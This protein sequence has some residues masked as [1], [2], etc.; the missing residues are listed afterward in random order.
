MLELEHKTYRWI[1]IKEHKVKEY[2]DKHGLLTPYVYNYKCPLTGTNMVEYHVESCK[3]FQEIMNKTTKWGGLSFRMPVGT[4]PMVLLGHNKCIYKQ[5]QFTGKSWVADNG[6]CPI[7]PK[8]KGAGLM[9]SNFQSREFGFVKPMTTTELQQV[10]EKRRSERYQDEE[11]AMLKRD[12][13][14]EKE[15][16]TKSPFSLI[17]STAPNIRATGC[18]NTLFFSVRILQTFCLSYILKSTYNSLLTTHTVTIT[19]ALMV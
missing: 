13:K 5:Y 12:S 14:K 4:K 18:T 8:D 10:N 6:S 19:N 3:N 1:Q 11:A 2:R 7:I 16:L 15:D 17:L 9:I